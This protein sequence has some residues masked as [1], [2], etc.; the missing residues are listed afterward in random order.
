MR[1]DAMKRTALLLLTCLAALGCDLVQKP[2]P[3]PML[4]ATPEAITLIQQTKEIC[5]KVAK[6]GVERMRS[7]EEQQK[8]SREE[9]MEAANNGGTLAAQDD[10]SSTAPSD[11]LEKY[12]S[13]EAA[14][15]LAA[16]DRATGLLRDLL[17]KVKDEA[18]PEIA[19]AV[20]SLSASEEQVCGRARNPRLGRLNYQEGLDYAVH[21]YDKAEAKLQALYTVTATDA[22]FAA[23]KYNPLLDEARAGTDRSTGSSAMKPLPPEE[24]RR[25]RKEWE[26]TQQ[27]QQEQQAQHDAAVVRWRQREEGKEP[28]L[29]KVGLAPA[30]EAKRNLSPEK[31][32]QSMRVWYA[33][34]TGKVGPVRTALAS[35]MSLRRG[36]LEQVTPACQDLLT[37]TSAM[38]SDPAM[39]DLPDD[40]AAKVLK[41]AYAELQACARACVAGLDA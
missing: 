4:T 35:Y 21:D 20:Q 13:D 41:K 15:E 31:R 36:S 12:L 32:A 10:T 23:N 9:A 3:A 33:G 7:A 19:Q 26:A 34:Y 24:L 25:Q 30:E 18:P 6:T 17:P 14:P 11:L 8:R 28:I 22:Q 16:A 38:V 5:V 40:A 27:Y 39:F 29:G 37:A 2:K 1:D